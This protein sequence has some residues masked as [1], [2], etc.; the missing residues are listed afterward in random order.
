MFQALERPWEHVPH[1][2]IEES[3]LDEAAYV[4]FYVGEL[5]LEHIICLPTVLKFYFH[6]VDEK[7][8]PHVK[9]H[10]NAFSTFWA[11]KTS[12]WTKSWK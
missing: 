9:D 5:L 11:F 1:F 2:G 12:I 3:Y 10:S 8:F 4:T 6:E 7:K